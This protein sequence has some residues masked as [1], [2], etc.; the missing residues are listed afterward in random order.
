MDDLFDQSEKS[1]PHIGDY[2]PAF[3]SVT[4]QGTIYFPADYFGKWVI[5]FSYPK[6]CTPVSIF[7]LNALASMHEDFKK[8]NCTM[9]GLSVGQYSRPTHNIVRKEIEYKG[10]KNVEIKITVIEDITTELAR[11]YGIIQP[12]KRNSKTVHSVFII[13][14]ECMIKGVINYPMSLGLN[15]DELKKVI[16]GLQIVDKKGIKTHPIMRSDNE[17][18]NT[19]NYFN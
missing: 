3:R 19:G 17:K 16:I 10:T 18:K 4:T 5:L 7:E 13:N 1:M 8:L 6:D 15:L 14:P 2:A 11:K 9:L 12:G